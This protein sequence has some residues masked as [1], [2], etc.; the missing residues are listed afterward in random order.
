ML[1]G[2]LLSGILHLGLLG[3]PASEVFLIEKT[4][5]DSVASLINASYNPK[6][7]FSRLEGIDKNYCAY[8][9]YVFCR[10]ESDAFQKISL[11]YKEDSALNK[12]FLYNRG[13]LLRIDFKEKNFYNISNKIFDQKGISA[14]HSFS[15]ELI[16]L[17]IWLKKF[18]DELR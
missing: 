17:G 15:D 12:S 7:F 4:K 14:E 9:A 8:T 18:V 1:L 3:Q 5:T 6:F 2:S 16:T 10:P 13:V 11:Y